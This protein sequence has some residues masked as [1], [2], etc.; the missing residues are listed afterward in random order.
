MKNRTVYFGSEVSHE[1]CITLRKDID[2]L[3]AESMEDP[4]TLVLCTP[5]GD[6]FSG[7]GLLD[8]LH[9]VKSPLTI[10]VQGI[11]LSMGFYI[12]QAGDVRVMSKSS[13]LMAH[14]GEMD[15]SAS[16]TAAKAWMNA[17][18]KAEAILMRMLCERTG[19][20]QRYWKKILGDG[21]DKIFSATEALKHKLIDKII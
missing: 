17:D 14:S 13:I 15:I 7:L 8:Y 20:D 5:G 11:C 12:L 10:E 1:S 3:V 6:L 2:E 18:K 4:I 21:S 16:P 19:K 9:N